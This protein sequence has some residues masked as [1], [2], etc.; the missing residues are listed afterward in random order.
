MFVEK[1]EVIYK[2]MCGIVDFVCDK[3]LVLKFPPASDKYNSARLLVYRENFNQVKCLKDS[4][5]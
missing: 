4:E 1:T 3:Y 2:D 5:K